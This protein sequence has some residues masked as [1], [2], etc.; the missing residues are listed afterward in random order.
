MHEANMKIAQVID[1]LRVGGAERLFVD[2]VNTLGA[3][4][5]SVILLSDNAIT[6]NLAETLDQDVDLYKIRVRKRTL[7][8]DIFRLAMLMRRLK[9]D[10]VHSHTFWPNLY[11]S[12]AARIAKVPVVFTSEHGRN[13]WKRP[14][15]RWS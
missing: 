4:N 6:P 2:L 10:V 14:W 13:E 11:A 3:E 12:L 8:V 5:V 1:E 9:L 7:F 15:H